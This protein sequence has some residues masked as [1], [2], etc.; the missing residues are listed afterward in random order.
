MFSGSGTGNLHLAKVLEGLGGGRREAGRPID[1][2]TLEFGPLGVGEL[3]VGEVEKLKS[4]LSQP[5]RPQKG[6]AGHQTE[7]ILYALPDC[8]PAFLEDS[9]SQNA[10][11]DQMV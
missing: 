5:G 7:N 2:E 3:L 11:L 9:F 6:L 4:D 1:A 8:C 10:L